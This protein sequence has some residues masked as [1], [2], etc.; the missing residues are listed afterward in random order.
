ML[1]LALW[2]SAIGLEIKLLSCF[3]HIVSALLRFNV[4]EKIEHVLYSLD[5]L[6]NH[7]SIK[8]IFSGF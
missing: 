7:L 3:F 5:K 1:N 8:L 2:S 6:R 4:S